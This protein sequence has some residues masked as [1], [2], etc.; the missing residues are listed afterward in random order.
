MKIHPR[1]R[2]TFCR[3]SQPSQSAAQT[4]SPSLNNVLSNMFLQQA[5]LPTRE[6]LNEGP[7]FPGVKVVI[8]NQSSIK[9]S[10]SN[11]EVVPSNDS[12]VLGLRRIPCAA[13]ELAARAAPSSSVPLATQRAQ[14]YCSQTVVQKTIFKIVFKDCF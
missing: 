9:S 11:P 3:Y 7:C 10:Y 12:G 14:K 1:I 4:R 6:F 13:S 8:P 5:A 2:Q